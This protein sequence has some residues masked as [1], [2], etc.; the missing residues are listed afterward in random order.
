M[1]RC[2]SSARPSTIGVWARAGWRRAPRP[3][4]WRASKR[5][6]H[7]RRRVNAYLHV[8]TRPK[9]LHA[10][11]TELIKAHSA[12]LLEREGSGCAALLRDARTDDL[13]RLYRVF[14][15]IPHGLDPV[16]IIFR[17]HVER[18]G[19]DAVRAATEAAGARQA[20]EREAGRAARDGAAAPEHVFIKAAIDLHERYYRYVESYFGNA[21]L[22]HK[23][24]KEAFETF[25][26]KL[27]SC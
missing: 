18:Q 16:A 22:F 4:T 19:L 15:R 3:S 13:T 1:S 20:K 26:N 9:L 2:F 23:S 6:Y 5:P 17:E 11:E 8:S 10:V 14:N 12:A 7:P 27:V 24:L 25:C 21:S